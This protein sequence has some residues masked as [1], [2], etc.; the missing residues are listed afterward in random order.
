MLS[1]IGG[2][3][4]AYSNTAEFV[5]VEAL[6]SERNREHLHHNV[7]ARTLSLDLRNWGVVSEDLVL[8]TH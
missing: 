4:D 5:A 1:G 7:K 8:Q 2:Q 3:D 6:H